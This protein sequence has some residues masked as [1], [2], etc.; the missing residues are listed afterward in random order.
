MKL[1]HVLLEVYCENNTS[2]P[3]YVV[4]MGLVILDTIVYL[5]IVR[6]SVILMLPMSL[7]MQENL[8]WY[9]IQGHGSGLGGTCSLM[10]KTRTKKLN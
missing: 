2:H 5:R 6:M 3:L 8:G 4:K 7:H 9:L 10:T 1:K